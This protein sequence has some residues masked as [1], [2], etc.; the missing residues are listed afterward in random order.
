MAPPTT[1]WPGGNS[2]AERLTTQPTKVMSNNH[3][4]RCN[5][6][7]NLTNMLKNAQIPS[8]INNQQKDIVYSLKETVKL[9]SDM[10]KNL[11]ECVRDI[12]SLF[13]EHDKNSLIN[14]PNTIANMQA[15]KNLQSE[16]WNI[17]E[18]RRGRRPLYTRPPPTPPPP[19]HNMY[20]PLLQLDSDEFPSLE[21]ANA[22][23]RKNSR[24]L[25]QTNTRYNSEV[26]PRP[27]NNSET[28]RPTY[29]PPR[30]FPP[31]QLKFKETTCH[32]LDA[33]KGYAKGH[34]VDQTLNMGAGVA[35]DFRK[36]IGQIESLKS[37][38]KKVGE[39]AVV[40]D[41]NGDYILYMISKRKHFYKP[42]PQYERLFKSNYIKA[43]YGLR[44][45][46]IKLKIKKLAIPKIGCCSDQLSWEHFMKPNILKIFDTVP[47]EILICDSK[48]GMNRSAK[49]SSDISDSTIHS[50]NT[51]SA[52]THIT[53]EDLI[54]NTSVTNNSNHVQTTPII[55]DISPNRDDTPSQI[56][57]PSPSTASPQ[58]YT[59][60]QNMS[61][62]IN[63]YDY[64]CGNI[65]MSDINS[66]NSNPI[67]SSYIVTKN[68]PR[69]IPFNLM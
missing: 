65:T 1:H 16:T 63:N 13:Y 8:A 48:P 12:E 34:S 68:M 30:V 66:N 44:K 55:N 58:V 3:C 15:N 59:Q 6:N 39:T 10:C 64:L 4:N 42:T 9:I 51:T 7:D 33:P 32:V 62:S 24:H 49:T 19:I 18:P 25:V 43:L 38:N 36:E 31:N 22:T 35:V 23:Y 37:Q 14:E 20:S 26:L 27:I 61:P 60:L 53:P 45:T 2:Y 40:K 50:L 21:S 54:T 28:Y 69:I 17:V 11:F 5:Y 52:G 67:T 57:R 29:R 46:C 41:A 47:I 56:D